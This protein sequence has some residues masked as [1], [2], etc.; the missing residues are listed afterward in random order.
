MVERD[1]EVI[2]QGKRK[3]AMC[4]LTQIR[5]EYPDSMGFRVIYS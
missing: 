1:L 2:S 5:L 4:C 3:P